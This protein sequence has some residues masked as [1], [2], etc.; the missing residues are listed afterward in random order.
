MFHS[1]LLKI[2]R[3]VS[4][5]FHLIRPFA[6]I[7]RH[8]FPQTILKPLLKLQVEFI[9]SLDDGLVMKGVLDGHICIDLIL[10]DSRHINT[11]CARFRR[12]T[13]RIPSIAVLRKIDFEYTGAQSRELSGF[14][15]AQIFIA[16]LS[17]QELDIL[18]F[19]LNDLVARQHNEVLFVDDP[20]EKTHH[21]A[22]A[23]QVGDIEFLT[24]HLLYISK[25]NL[26]VINKLKI[27]TL[28]N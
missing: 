23:A 16:L 18:V 26:A 15:S 3:P 14:P 8:N 6:V 27:V 21:N 5:E 19:L 12:F 22:C 13:A 10:R 9:S 24:P 17:N 20:V 11:H 25:L 28:I 1:D 2:R 4:I 7:F